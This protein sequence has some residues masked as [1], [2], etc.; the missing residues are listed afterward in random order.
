[1]TGWSRGSAGGGGGGKDC[2]SQSMSADRP[3]VRNR[4]AS[5]SSDRDLPHSQYDMRG[6][7]GSRS[8]SQSKESPHKPVIGRASYGGRMSQ[9]KERQS[10]ISAARRGMQGTSAASAQ[11]SRENSRSRQEKGFTPTPPPQ[12]EPAVKLNGN[13]LLTEDKARDVTVC[14]VG[15]YLNSRD[16][17][18]VIK[19][20]TDDFHVDTMHYF[21]Y[22]SVNHTLEQSSGCRSHVSGLL[23]TLVKE[24]M[25][26]QQQLVKGL[27]LLMD[28]D[29]GDFLIDIPKFFEYIG[30]I[31]ESVISEAVVPMS[32]LLEVGEQC[33]KDNYG[34]KL[35]ANLLNIV[36]SKIGSQ[37][38]G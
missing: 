8:G 36:K 10:A 20:L 24:R 13:P 35:L 7:P 30:E 29:M 3:A 15:E 18:E 22:H 21:V 38:L 2:A 34:G 11:S 26:S 33:I 23:A 9:E 12:P 27:R 4:F 37:K 6:G 32:F 5:L 16:Q 28:A 14:I 31:L 25:I 17:K 1:M 19:C